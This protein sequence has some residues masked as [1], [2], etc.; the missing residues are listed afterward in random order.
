M[1]RVRLR[2]RLIEGAQWLMQPLGEIRQQ[3]IRINAEA[4]MVNKESA[5]PW[6]ASSKLNDLTVWRPPRQLM[7]PTCA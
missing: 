6:V 3:G 4:M 7:Q 1:L 5:K 2:V